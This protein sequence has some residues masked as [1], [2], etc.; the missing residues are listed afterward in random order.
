MGPFLGVQSFGNGLLQCGLLSMAAGSAR[1]PAPAWASLHKLQFLPKAFSCV[2]FTWAAV[3]LRAHP[4]FPTWSPPWAAGESLLWQLNDLL[5][6]F[7]TDFDVCRA[8]SLTFSPSSLTAAAQCFSP[9]LKNIIV[10]VQLMSLTGSVLASGGSI[11]ELTG[12][13]SVWHEASFWSLLTDAT[14]TVPL[15]PKPCHVKPMEQLRSWCF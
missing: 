1:K 10:E 5:L 9:F 14:P 8:V 6:C 7:F 15:L 13:G 11:L 2:S 3:S 12:A 4:C